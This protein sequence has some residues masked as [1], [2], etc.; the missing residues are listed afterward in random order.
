MG[1]KLLSEIRKRCKGL[2][3]VSCWLLTT[4]LVAKLSFV[5]IPPSLI[6]QIPQIFAFVASVIAV[7]FFEIPS[8]LTLKKVNVLSLHRRT[9]KLPSSLQTTADPRKCNKAAVYYI[10][11]LFTSALFSPLFIAILSSVLL[12][13][14]VESFSSGVSLFCKGFLSFFVAFEIAD[15]SSNS[16]LFAAMGSFLSSSITTLCE[17]PSGCSSHQRVSP[18]S[19]IWPSSPAS[20]VGVLEASYASQ[21]APTVLLFS[22]RIS[23]FS[24]PAL[25]LSHQKMDTVAAGGLFDPYHHP[26]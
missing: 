13:G 12:R 15:F 6:G 10:G 22:S 19:G 8:F 25:T 24:L 14:Q 17:R 18:A 16:W 3:S 7:F 1:W 9:C 23:L 26:I 4:F 2:S 21:L 11:N 5:L 20:R